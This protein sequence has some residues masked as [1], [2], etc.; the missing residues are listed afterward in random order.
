M[1]YI[2]LVLI[3][4]ISTSLTAGLYFYARKYKILDMPTA[5]SSHEEPTPRGG[6]LAIVITFSITIYFLQYFEYINNNDFMA[7]FVGG[8]IIAGIGFWDDHKHVPARWRIVVHIMA[9]LWGLFW[10]GEGANYNYDNGI[11]EFGWFIDLM[12][13]LFIVWLLNLYNFMD[14]LD[15]IAS[16]EAITVSGSAAALIMY[17]AVTSNIENQYLYDESIK[18]S[19]QLMVLLV[20]VLGFLFWNLPPA[21]IFMGDVGSAYLGYVLAIFTISTTINSIL[22]IWVWL[23]L[24]GVFLVDTTATLI[25]RLITG[26]RWYEA[27]RTH[28][29]Q[30]A[31]QRW[32]SHKKVTMSVLIIN[33][34]WLLPLA[35]LSMLKTELGPVFTLIAYI[36]LFSA[37]FIL[38]AG[39]KSSTHE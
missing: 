24:L 3:L 28:A 9:A 4:L 25:T 31:A 10:L 2:S 36:P 19:I 1:F 29:Y 37:A 8:I 5:R 21:K 35:W 27:H 12:A 32:Q 6:G 22:T 15:G 16:I 33:I 20:C 23:I 39:K 17:T 13:L 14:G 7:L 30:H 34:L 26:Q 11:L 38:R 18:Y